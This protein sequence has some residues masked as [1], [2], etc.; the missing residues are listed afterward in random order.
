M[1]YKQILLTRPP[2][3]SNALQGGSD[4]DPHPQPP[5]GLAYLA[6]VLE[7][8]SDVNVLDILDG[9]FSE[10]YVYDVKMAVKKHNPDLVGF[11]A[12]TPFAN[13]ALEATKAVKE[14][15]SE[16][17]TVLGGPHAVLADVTMRKCPDLDV[18]VYDEGE[19]Q[20]EEIVSGKPLDDIAE[21][22]LMM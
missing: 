12:F 6:G 14:I 19:E 3:G 21:N 5:L 10:N 7:R 4:A 18:I 11:S 22:L 17:L 2:T 13:P 16:I 20:I 1:R 8:L 9:N 15:N